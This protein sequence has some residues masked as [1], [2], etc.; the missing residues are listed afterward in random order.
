M[1]DSLGRETSEYSVLAF[2]V[3]R[4]HWTTAPRRLSG[5][6]KL[7]SDGRYRISGLPPG[8]YYLSVLTD[9]DPKQ[10]S[11]PSVLESLIPGSIKISLGE[12]EKKTQNLQLSR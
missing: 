4:S 9:V 3:D 8:D 6:V 2:S 5:A 12:G 10:A 7:S 11:D 1:V